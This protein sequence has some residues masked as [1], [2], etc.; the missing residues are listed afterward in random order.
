MKY[1]VMQDKASGR[2]VHYAYVVIILHVS[3]GHLYELI[4]TKANR[5][6]ARSV[7]HVLVGKQR[8]VAYDV[9][10]VAFGAM[11]N[12]VNGYIAVK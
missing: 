3:E 11:Y 4:I 9:D 7:D 10:L 6:H 2:A 8:I 1:I 12:V 5:G